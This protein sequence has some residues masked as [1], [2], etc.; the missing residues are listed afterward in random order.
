MLSKIDKSNSMFHILERGDRKIAKV[1]KKAI[2][3]IGLSRA[4]KSTL[5]NLL[6]NKQLKG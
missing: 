2:M 4:G 1:N 3:L 5:Y 6:L